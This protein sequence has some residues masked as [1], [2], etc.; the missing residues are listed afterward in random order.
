M[1]GS[2]VVTDLLGRRISI[3]LW[4]QEDS[5]MRHI[6]DGVLRAVG[7]RDDS[8]VLMVQASRTR[9][10][11]RTPG[12]LNVFTL[13]PRG[14]CEIL[15]IEDESDAMRRYF[16]MRSRMKVLRATDPQT[17]RAMDSSE[18]RE[19]AA[20]VAGRLAEIESLTGEMAKVW[21]C[22]SEEERSVV[23]RW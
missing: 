9:P 20:D 1:N 15:L 7:V 14:G 5:E 22:L 23:S 11:N 16:E 17:L 3:S 13:G 12:S 10:G 18:W 8:F 19:R 4:S 6:M 21:D 2:E